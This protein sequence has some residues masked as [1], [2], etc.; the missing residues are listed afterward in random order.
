M[1]FERVA[2]LSGVSKTTLY[3]W[4]PSKGALA[5]DGCFHTVQATLDF[6]DTGD[7][8]TDLIAQLHSFAH[9]MTQ[10]PGGKIL[11]QLIGLA[12]IDGEL[13][14]AYQAA[15]SSQRRRLGG[16]RLQQAQKLGQVRADVDVQVLVDQLWG[17]VHHRLL[18]P[19]EPV[20]DDFL[21]ALVNNLMDGV[22]QNR[23]S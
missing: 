7:I 15:Y 16:E 1:S 13:A 23:T 17:A 10:T 20:T 2:K 14:T 5:L 3:K 22:G 21:V 6:P 4:W 11:T 12:Q 19:D 9:V 18:I 8:R